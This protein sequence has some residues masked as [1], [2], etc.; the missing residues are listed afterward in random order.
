[1][2]LLPTPSA[3]DG[4]G[5]RLNADG[6]QVTL[7]GT[8][9]EVWGHGSTIAD[10]GRV[11]RG[12]GRV[13]ASG[14][15]AQGGHSVTIQDVA[16]H[17]ITLLPTTTTRDAHASGGSTP[18]NVTLTDA[19][20]R[21]ELGTKP[22]GRHMPTP[23]AT[24]G[25]SATEIAYGLG[26]ERVDDDRPQGEV[27]LAATNWGPYAAAVERWEPVAG[28][29]PSPVRHDGKGGK[30]RL[31]PELPEWMMGLKRGHITAA[32]IGLTRAEQLKAAGNGVVPQQAEAATV[33]L[34]TRAPEALA[35]L[36]G[37]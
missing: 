36:L 37:S 15:A 28:T 11:Q 30:A 22:N 32:E 14:Q 1:M 6:H 25:G 2:S 33:E 21:T 10:A 17:E 24:R 23:R 18:S 29:A 4:S 19:V 5:G 13:A 9:W 20:V 16:E 31:N 3:A 7:P 12:P 34:L 27:T 8:V 35:S 26:G